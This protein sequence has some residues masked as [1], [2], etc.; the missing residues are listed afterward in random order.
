MLVTN[1]PKQLPPNLPD[2]VRSFAYLPF[3]QILPRCSALVYPGGIGTMA[4]AIKAAIPHLVVPYGHDQPD[5]AFRVY[6]S[7]WDT[8]FTRN[9]IKP[10]ASPKP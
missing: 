7:V 4:Q 2:G 8:A 10:L 3:S 9:A 1:F 6:A 5:N